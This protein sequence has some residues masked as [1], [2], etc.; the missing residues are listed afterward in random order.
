MQE[1]ITRNDTRILQ[2]VPLLYKDIALV[3]PSDG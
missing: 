1:I 3:D 2:A